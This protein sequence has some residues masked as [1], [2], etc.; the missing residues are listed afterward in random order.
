MSAKINKM[1][2]FD[3]K[4]KHIAILERWLQ[5]AFTKQIVLT[6]K[7]LI[8]KAKNIVS[9]IRKEQFCSSKK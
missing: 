4:C 2:I 7:I 6:D 9:S 8:E 1:L 3:E 5:Y